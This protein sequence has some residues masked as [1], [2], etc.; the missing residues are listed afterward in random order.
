MDGIGSGSCSAAGF[1]V[2]DVETWGSATT[3]LV[4]LAF[5]KS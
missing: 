5:H 4:M 2:S 1:G 3:G